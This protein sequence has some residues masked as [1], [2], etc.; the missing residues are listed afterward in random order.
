MTTI[1]TMQDL[2]R[3]LREHPEWRDEL[4]RELLTDE[5]LQL[6]QRFAEYTASTDARLGDI[7]RRLDALT[8]TVEKLVQYAEATDRRLDDIDRRLDALAETVG[9]LVQRAEAADRRLDRIERN[10]DRMSNDFRNFRWN[11]AESATVKEFVNIAIDLNDIKS[12][13]IDETSAKIVTQ[14][15]LL[16][17]AS[18][19]GSEN[20]SAIPKGDRQSFYRSDL[21]IKTR[22]Q[23]GDTCYI[24]V[25]A[26][27]TCDDRDIDRALTHAELITTFT[28]KAAW[29][30]VASVRVDNRIQQNIDEGDVFWYPLDEECLHP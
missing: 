9:K 27:Y 24:A 8:E 20:L 28:Q 14:D 6:P 3:L 25:E 19:Y 12:L 10:L 2:T 23:D 30:V 29:P 26:S 16:A 13:G 22:L 11:Y 21:V 4:R 5:L 7:D 15:E 17:M 18:A 1:N